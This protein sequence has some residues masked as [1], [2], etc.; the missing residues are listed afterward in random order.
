V[1]WSVSTDMAIPAA[2]AIRPVGRLGCRTSD[3]TVELVSW[4]VSI[5]AERPAIVSRAG[6]ATTAAVVCHAKIDTDS[7]TARVASARAPGKRKLRGPMLV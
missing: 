7:A 4:S 1:S 6:G 5:V 2:V 3:G